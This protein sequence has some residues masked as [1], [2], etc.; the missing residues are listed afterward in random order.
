MQQIKQISAPSQFLK[1]LVDRSLIHDQTPGLSGALEAAEKAGKSPP[2]YAGFDPSAASLQVGNLVAAL[3]LRRAQLFGLKPIVLLG[4][5][6][7]LIGDPSGKKAERTLLDPQIAEANVAKIKGQLSLLVGESVRFVNNYDWFKDFGYIDFLR[8]VGKHITINYMTAKD[9]VKLRMDTGISYAEFGYMLIQ[10]YDF[11]HLFESEKCSIQ[12][13][14][15]DQWGNMTT[16]IELI[17]RKHSSEAHAFSAPL[18]TDSAGN[19][20]GKSEGG[21]IYL[22]AGMTS[23]YQFHQYWLNQADADVGKI[24]RALTLLEMDSLREL[25]A[26]TEREPDKRLAQR[27][28]AEEVTGL[29]HGKEAARAAEAAAKVMFSKDPTSLDRIDARTLEFLSRE[30]PSSK[31]A[32]DESIGILDL[33]V[34]SGLAA[35][36]G[37]AR[38]SLQGN[39]VSINRVKV[40]DEKLVLSQSSFEA[41]PFLLLG[42]GKAKL[43]LVMID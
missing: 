23:P 10:G 42:L 3:L 20:L 39:A 43:H 22:D 4:G 27:I 35:S 32:R 28:L 14:G 11:L 30:V 21:A 1:H 9:S 36:K 6:T 33:L 41:R 16:G 13:G 26:A 2:V 5:A 37:E 25:D 40:N 24:L 38:R 18:L 8:T 29:V 7:G 12:T 15:S 17:R 31:F 34:R 19:K